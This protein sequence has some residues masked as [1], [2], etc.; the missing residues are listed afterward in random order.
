VPSAHLF[1][2]F[3]CVGFT[4][5]PDD[6][7]HCPSALFHDDFLLP[8]NHLTDY[9]LVFRSPTNGT[10][11]WVMTKRLEEGTFSWPRKVEPGQE[12]L[13]LRPEA[14]AMLT[15]G[16][17]LRGA[18][19]RPWYEREAN[20]LA[21]IDQLQ[22]ENELLR[23]KLDLVLRRMFGAKSEKFD[24]GQ[25][26]L[27][28]GSLSKKVEPAGGNAP[29]LKEK[30]LLT[31]PSKKDKRPRLPEHLPVEEEVVIHLEVQTQPQAWREM[32]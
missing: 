29:V 6:L 20:Y 10:G 26:E 32:G 3:A 25:L 9:G 8:E 2:C 7:L 17:E 24:A 1:H 28:L 4:Q 12:R 22:K 19:M 11:L 23:Q 14:L 27:L 13:V 30:P 18:K 21:K 16:I 31:P 5:N 15:D